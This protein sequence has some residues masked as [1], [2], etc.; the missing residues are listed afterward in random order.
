M[1]RRGIGL[2]ASDWGEGL[3]AR[4]RAGAGEGLIRLSQGTDKGRPTVGGT[5]SD[6][7]W[8]RGPDLPVKPEGLAMGDGEGSDSVPGSEGPDPV[9]AE[10]PRTIWWA[11]RDWPQCGGPRDSVDPD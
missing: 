8:E 6:H 2:G 3:G 11:S 4:D 9:G 10:M 1:G 7:D 5:A